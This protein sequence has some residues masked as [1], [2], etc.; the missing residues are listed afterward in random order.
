M[1]PVNV[2]DVLIFLNFFSGKG[3]KIDLLKNC[4]FERKNDE[5][6][7]GVVRV[8]SKQMS[9]F[10]SIPNGKVAHLVEDR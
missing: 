9:Y 3:F 6:C 1:S 8:I 4:W 10:N 2:I 5:K 7:I